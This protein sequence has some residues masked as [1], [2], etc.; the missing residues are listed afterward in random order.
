MRWSKV[1]SLVEA[2]FSEKLNKRVQIYSTRYGECTCGR[3]W[4]TLD[5]SEIANFC[6]RAHYNKERESVQPSKKSQARFD[7]MP[8]EYG[9]LSRQDAYRACWAFLHELSLEEALSDSD[10][11]VQ[12]LAVLDARLGKRRLRALDPDALHPLAEKLWKLRMDAEGLSVGESRK[13]ATP[14]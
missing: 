10:P 14:S 13:K 6:T 5:G 12:T 9:E 3:A 7:T 4:L 1:K 11:L 2:R 8:V